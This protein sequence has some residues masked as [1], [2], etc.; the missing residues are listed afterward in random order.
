MLRKRID[1][2]PSQ[3]PGK[4]MFSARALSEAPVSTGTPKLPGGAAHQ[5]IENRRDVNL[6]FGARD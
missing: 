4:M 6:L 2:K 5:V 1:G 3:S